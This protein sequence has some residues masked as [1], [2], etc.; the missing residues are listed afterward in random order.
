MKQGKTGMGR[1]KTY[2]RDEGNKDERRSV[3]DVME[4]GTDF[5][6]RGYSGGWR[7]RTDFVGDPSVIGI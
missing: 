3:G 2:V 1:R 5:G 6:N 7:S 4:I